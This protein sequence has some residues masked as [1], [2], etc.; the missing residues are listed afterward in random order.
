MYV[1]HVTDQVMLFIW[2]MQALNSGGATAMPGPSDFLMLPG[3]SAVALGP[4]CED[5]QLSLSNPA[6]QITN[7]PVSHAALSYGFSAPASSALMALRCHTQGSN[8][9][10]SRLFHTLSA[11]SSP[12]PDAAHVE[13]LHALN[14]LARNTIQDGLVLSDSRNSMMPSGLTSMSGGGANCTDGNM[15]EYLD[16]YGGGNDTYTNVDTIGQQVTNCQH[17]HD[18]HSSACAV[19]MVTS[20][21][22]VCL[23][24]CVGKQSGLTPPVPQS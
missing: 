24:R 18:Q 13:Q 11:G 19:S 17:V 2:F 20:Q 15:F 8:S 10:N 3:C 9:L 7:Q 23:A 16:Q 22:V 5:V 4:S 1:G 6:Q 14:H 12:T 21:Q